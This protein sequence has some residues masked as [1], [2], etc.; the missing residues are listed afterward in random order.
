MIE[1]L[2][3]TIMLLIRADSLIP[4]TRIDVAAR[5]ISIAGKFMNAPVEFQPVD[6][7]PATPAVTLAGVHHWNGALDSAEGMCQPNWLKRL[8]RWPDQ[9]TP[10]VAAP[11]AYSST[12]S[13]PMIQ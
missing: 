9:P 10:T 11:A 4:M 8:T 5:T 6:T 7:H 1:T 12:R 13:Q 2:R 3:I